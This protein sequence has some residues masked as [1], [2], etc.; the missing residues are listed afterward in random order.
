MAKRSNTRRPRRRVNR[1]RKAPKSQALKVY[2][3]IFSQLPAYVKLVGQQCQ[4]TGYTTGSVSTALLAPSASTAKS[5][6]S[7]Y[8]D[9]GQAFQ[10]KLQDLKNAQFY[11]QLYDQWR[12]DSI[13]LTIECLSNNAPIGGIALMP[14]VYMSPDYDD[15]GIPGL[16]Q[17][18]VGRPGMKMFKFG[19]KM[20]TSYTM[21]IKPKRAALMYNDVVSGIGY[22]SPVNGWND[23]NDP[24]ITYYGIKAF[25]TDV[26][27]GGDGTYTAFKIDVKYNLAF[28][29]PIT[30]C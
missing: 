7:G 2:R 24:Q 16:V 1:K 5:G 29:T 11:T 30:A 23:C 9:F 6:F 18:V 8:Y 17:D 14:T 28:R 3:T 15:A 25:Y 19:N 27:G 10:F 12:L 21:K 4:I 20:K 22:S 13:T 26:L